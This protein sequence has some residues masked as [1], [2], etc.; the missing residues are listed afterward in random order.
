MLN[1]R[2]TLSC[3]RAGGMLTLS[4]V[5]GLATLSSAAFAASDAPSWR[6]G[7]ILV[8]PQAQQLARNVA[9]LL[10]NQGARAL[11]SLPNQQVLEVAVPIGTEQ[12][13]ASELAND[14]SIAFAEPDFLVAPADLTPNDPKYGS[15]WHLGK[16]ESSRAWELSRGAGITIAILD[17]GVDA[18]HPD[19]APKLL[20]GWNVVNRNGETEDVNGH[21]T[22]VAGSAASATNNATGVAAVGWDASLLPVRI[23]NRSDGAAYVSDIA[24]GITWAADQGARVANV[25]YNASGSFT[26]S[27]A[28]AYMR[29]QGGLV[30]ISAGNSGKDIGLADDPGIITVSA[31]TSKDTKASWSNYGEFIDVA[32]P[33]VSILTTSTGGRYRTWSG[34]SFASPVTAG[35]VALILSA[36]PLLTADEVEQIL[37]D[38]ADDIGDPGWDSRFGA[39]RVNAGA[40]VELALLSEEPIDI[41]PTVSLI[42]PVE[43]EFVTGDVRI[44]IAASDDIGIAEVVLSVDGAEVGRMTSAPYEVVWDSTTVA[45]GAVTLT[46]QAFD[47]AGNMTSTSQDVF[48]ANEIPTRDTTPPVVSFLSPEDG[49]DAGRLVIIRI[50][51]TDD[52][53]VVALRLYHDD[54]LLAVRNGASEAR[55]SQ[56]HLWGTYGEAAGVHRLKVVAEDAAGNQGESSVTVRVR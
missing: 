41:A 34:T 23:T 24:R 16:I 46:A 33:G 45:N 37:E 30:V 27:N 5:I 1:Q 12:Q 11:G 44:Q 53:G 22:A 28:A 17:S 51:A 49:S 6:E 8:K 20:P 7:R 10:R 18:D 25:S 47:T 4:F 21:G 55:L 35:V 36:N 9:T 43:G 40:A 13:V 29:E 48:I 31:T 50:L 3:V 54:R 38:S 39:G 14:P 42:T 15:A 26:V 32:A 2:P 56:N 52:D 19:L